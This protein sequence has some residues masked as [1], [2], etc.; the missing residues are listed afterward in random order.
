MIFGLGLKAS[1]YLGVKYRNLGN[2]IHIRNKLKAF[3]SRYYKRQLL[4][5]SFLF[6]FLGG[7]LFL[8]IGALEY[9][10]WLSPGFR[11]FLLWSGTLLEGY[12]V[13]RYII[14]PLLHLFRL[15]KGLTHKEGSRLIGAHFPEVS[16]KLYNLLELAENKEQSELLLAS[17]DQR[18]EE[19][20]KVPFQMAIRMEESL[21]YARYAAIPVILGIMI[22]LSGKGLDFIDSYERVVNYELAYDPPAPF[23]FQLLNPTLRHRE[24]KPFVLKVST[25]G[26]IRPGQVRLIIQGKPFVMEDMGTH[27][28]FAF[29]PPL[30]T[31]NFSLDAAGISSAEYTLEIVRVPVIDRF[32]MSMKY[33]AYLQLD[34]QTVEGTGNVTVPEGTMVKW[35]IRTLH[36]DSLIYQDRD[37][38]FS[39][40]AGAEGTELKKEIWSATDYAINASN[41][42]IEEFDKL[43]YRIDVVRDEYPNILVKMVRDSL[44]VNLAYFAGEIS[45]DHKIVAL[46]LICYPDGE[47]KRTQ[48]LDLQIPNTTYANFYYTFPSGL[49]IDPDRDY[50]LYFLARDND[51]NRGG[52]A[53]KSREFS[54]RI[55]GDE[56]LKKEQLN[57]QNRS[58]EEMDRSVREQSQLSEKFKNLKQNQ[59]EKENISFDEKQQLKEFLRKQEQQERLMEKFSR[60]LSESMESEES[61][62][63]DELLKERLERQEI[64]ARKN[65]E[66]MKQL[67]EV[68]DKLD[69]QELQ[70]RLEEISKS[71]NSNKR[72]LEQL[73]ELSKRYYVQEKSKQLGRALE[74][75]AEEQEIFSDSTPDKENA[76][77][78]QEL[79]N[80][81]FGDLRKELKQLDED[82]QGLKK[83]LPWNRD[84]E[85]E[86]SVVEDQKEA[87]DKIK[88]QEGDESEERETTKGA[89]QK[90]KSAARK[91]KE[92]S[93]E[94][95]QGAS[96]GGSESLAEDADMLRQ[97][98]DNLL[99]FS[100]EQ[101]D[102]FGQIQKG[103][104]NPAGRSANVRKQRQLREVFE[105]VDDSLFA[106]SLRRAEISEIVNKQITEVYYNLDKSLESFGQSNW[107]RGAS[108]QQYVVTATNEL[109][110]FLAD[111]LDN[112]QQSL[113]PGK[114]E[115]QGMDFQLPDI[116]QS[117]QELQQRMQNGKGQDSQGGKQQKGQ[118]NAEGK[119]SKKGEGDSEGQ[120]NKGDNGTEGD[121]GMG[122]QE[123]GKSGNSGQEGEGSEGE[124][125][126]A[127]YFEI[128]KEQQKIRKLLEEQLSDLINETDRELAAKIAREMELF[129]EEL[130]RNGITQKT[131]ERLNRI[132]QQLLKLENAAL[133]QGK[134]EE[135]EGTT[136]LT[137]FENPVLTKPEVFQKRQMDIE[138]LNRQA[139]PLRRIY[140]D[141]VQQYFRSNDSIPLPNGI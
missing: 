17:I 84:V 57:L 116:I 121:E 46:K 125:N 2:Y 102:L 15:R 41:A 10:L 98:L 123:K 113:K 49:N 111:L 104:D 100:I 137:D 103:R 7:A 139:L 97:I 96:S 132:Q 6:L 39:M 19:L 141:K 107:Y 56:N 119:G 99:V 122:Q 83:P 64:E 135:R 28:E 5:G 52:K 129:E 82:N 87:L 130:L 9:F 32:E 77:K 1:H 126:Y 69:K 128:Y 105:H 25:P 63:E 115:G 23:R 12:L 22:W 65:A 90:Q 67:Q 106:L 76:P 79:L 101:E 81:E 140:R 18:S 85:K 13:V 72:N 42:D 45:D 68:L 88:Q 91:L 53:R 62:R 134:T 120:G 136:N 20:N 110:S 26:E 54:M 127:E 14:D 73:L 138:I 108:Y 8:I 38:L 27:F 109:A 44:E 24:D 75:L 48:Q 59:K 74:K 112:M 35:S 86:E 61:S 131:S 30:K 114:G 117:Q 118:E 33:P 60:E 55:L 80:T 133:K 11:S 43:K 31:L 50:T 36:A 124:E 70:E 37:T 3:V 29:R 4:K 34:D 21:K 95:N 71:Q 93:E 94:L 40:P 47:E 66:L 51:G 89:K 16:D 58:V 92:L 78:E